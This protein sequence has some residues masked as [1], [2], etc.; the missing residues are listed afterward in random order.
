MSNFKEAVEFLAKEQGWNHLYNF[1]GVKT[2]E[3]IDSPGFNTRKWPRL[4]KVF[5]KVKIN[6]KSVIDV[7]CSDGYF[8]VKMAEN[9]AN[10]IGID[11]DKKRIKK[12]NF[13]KEFFGLN[14]LE[15]SSTNLY[16]LDSNKEYD[17]SVALGLI[18]RIPDIYMALE[19]LC[20]ISNSVLLEYKALKEKRPIC[21]WGGSQ[22]KLNKLNQLYFIPTNS[23]IE[24][25]MSDFGFKLIHSDLDRKSKLK[26]KRDIQLFQK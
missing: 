6:D 7:G 24:G 2:R 23:F 13:A 18:H 12:A 5:Q 11:P 16:D 25:I 1:D 22:I 17:M 8:S 4:K 10:V 14:N 15:F 3:A 9:G 21:L 20:S 26:Y 19:K